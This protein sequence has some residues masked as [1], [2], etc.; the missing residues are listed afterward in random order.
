MKISIITVTYNSDRTLRDTINS[1]VSQTYDNWELVIVDGKSKDSTIDI[2]N[3]YTEV[4][5]D[6]IIWISEP[7]KGIYDAMNKG[8]RMATGDI[9]GIL[10][11]DDFFFDENVL[12]TIHEAFCK[13]GT[14]CVF[15]NLVYVNPVNTDKIERIWRGSEY[16][17]GKFRYSWVPAHPTFYVKREC[18]LRYGGYNTSFQVS[19]DFELM[20]RYLAKH[21]LSSKYVDS[22][23]V[24]MRSGGESN[25]SLQKILLGNKNI[26]RAFKENGQQY[27]RLYPIYRLVPKI[28][29]K[30]EISVMN[31]LHINP[32]SKY[33]K[34]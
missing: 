30:I 2:I 16:S 33:G 1:I 18:Y 17:D 7:D 29:Q 6:R 19:A 25:G 27:P 10:N 3:S 15:G 31:L 28:F 9:V 5:N 32:L 12:A 21:K 4:Y 26:I 14:D 34:K 23:F 24:R 11:S 22:F 13:Y 20:I 8:I